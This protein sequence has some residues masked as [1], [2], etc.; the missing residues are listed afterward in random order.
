MIRFNLWQWIFMLLV[1][2]VQEGPVWADNP[3]GLITKVQGRVMVRLTGEEKTTP[4]KAGD[5]V[6]IGHLIQTEKGAKVQL[7][8]A[9]H[10]LVTILPE[11][12]LRLNQY[13][14]SSPEKRT[15]AIIQVF[16]GQMRFIVNARRINNT[17]FT[18]ETRQAV[19]SAAVS[20]FIIKASSKD[21]EVTVLAEALTVKNSSP[22]T[23]GLVR[24]D[25][26]QKTVVREKV[27][28][29]QPTICPLDLR[30]T[31]INDATF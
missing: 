25:T 16:N 15:R 3:A 11:S 27:P 29:A 2:V 26:N 5:P 30:R 7:V 1:F 20:D 10:S 13:A 4:V 28:P 19:I 14:Y 21:T 23:V 17:D 9:D 18:I 24:L 6:L 12:E 8:F 22:L 31:Y